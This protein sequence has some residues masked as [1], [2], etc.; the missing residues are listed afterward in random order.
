MPGDNIDQKNW[1][2]MPKGLFVKNELQKMA[3]QQK[4]EF[5]W[6]SF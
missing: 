5:L 1:W 2:Y 6:I 4:E 3:K